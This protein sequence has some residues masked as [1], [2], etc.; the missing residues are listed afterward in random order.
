MSCRVDGFYIH[1]F[2]FPCCH[3]QVEM[4]IK[5]EMSNMGKERKDEAEM[6]GA[7]LLQADEQLLNK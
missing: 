5:R 1:L 3:P 2:L 7:S 4:S 6:R